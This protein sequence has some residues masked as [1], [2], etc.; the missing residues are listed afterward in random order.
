MVTGSIYIPSKLSSIN[1][2]QGSERA[3]SQP[4]QLVPT[5][6]YH[7]SCT[8]LLYSY[9]SDCHIVFISNSLQSTVPIHHPSIPGK[10]Y[11]ILQAASEMS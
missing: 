1:N 11:F 4:G 3:R 2:K 8:A 10:T 5:S 6:I 9:R 7:M